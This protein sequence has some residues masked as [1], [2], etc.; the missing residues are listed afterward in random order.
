MRA[1]FR[2]YLLRALFLCITALSTNASADYADE[3]LAAV[4]NQY[5]EEE[6]EGYV[7]NFTGVS[8]VEYIRFV[9]K[10]L[11]INFIFDETEL[12]FNVTIV[13]EE[14]VSGK[15]V[16]SALIQVLRIHNLRLIE[17]NGSLLITSNAGVNA[18]APVIAEAIP[19][20]QEKKGPL[21]TRIFLIKNTSAEAIAEV[22]RPL[23]STAALIEVMAGS[24]LLIVSDILTNVDQIAELLVSLDS[25]Q[26]HLE[27]DTFECKNH[28]PQVLVS[29]AAQILSPFQQGK[30]LL[31]VPQLET[32]SIFIVSTTALIERAISVL[33]D[34]DSEAKG[35]VGLERPE[36]KLFLYKIRF[37]SP[38]FLLQS[39][40]NIADQMKDAPMASPDLLQALRSAKSIKDTHSL[41]FMGDEDSLNKIEEMLSSLDVEKPLVKVLPKERL[42]LYKIQHKSPQFL[43]QSLK[44]ILSEMQEADK[45]SPEL[46]KSLE[47]VQWIKDSH[48]LMFMGDD[49]SIATIQEILSTVD[50]PA[51]A[52]GAPG[53]FLFPLKTASKDQVQAWLNQIADNLSEAPSPDEALIDTIRSAKWIEASNSLFF[54][55]NEYSINRLKEILSSFDF[56]KELPPKAPNFWVYRPAVRKGEEIEAHV[57]EVTDNLKAAGLTNP[58][59]LH[60]LESMQWSSSANTLTFTGDADSL[61]EIKTIVQEYDTAKPAVA[62]AP[63]FWVYHPV[64]RKGEEIEAHVK[65]VTA[66]LKD[67]GLTNPALLNALQSLRW[68]PSTN[69]LTFTGDADSLDE[70]KIIVQEYDTAK[71]AVPG[72]SHFWVYHPAVRKGEEIEAHVKEVTAN[73]KAAGLTNPPLLKALASMQWSPSANTL[74]FTGDTDS[75]NEIKV[76]VEQ[77]D[78]VKPTAPGAP[79]FLVY[80]PVHRKGEEIEAH[81][82]EVTANLKA[83]GLTNPPFLSALESMRWS[84]STN[85]LTFTGDESSLDEIKTIVEGYD[86]KGEAVDL[87]AQLAAK[88]TSFFIYKPI[89]KSP[90]EIQHSLAEIASDLEASGLADPLLLSTL[91]TVR[92]VE[93]TQSF[94]FTGSLDSLEKVSGLLTRIDL[95]TEE[96]VSI[97][98]IGEETFLIYKIQ[99]VTANQLLAS[100]KALTSDL[101]QNEQINRSLIKTLNSAKWVQETNSLLFIGPE[102]SLEEVERLA[103]Q[104]D[105]PSLAKPGEALIEP[106]ETPSSYL[107][108]T[109]KYQSGPEL[110][111]MV[112]EFKDHLA[113]IGIVDKA[114][115]DTV[116]HLKWVEKSHAILI[117]GAP[118]SITKVEELLERFDEPVKGEGLPTTIQALETTSFLVYKLQY[119]QGSAI[120]EALQKIAKEFSAKDG[121]INKTMLDAIQSLQ[122]IQITNSLVSTGTSLALEKLKELIRN[123]D[124]PLKQV[125]IEVLLIET[126]LENTQDFGLQWGSKTQY[127]N[128]FSMATGNFPGGSVSPSPFNLND[129]GKPLAQGGPLRTPIASDVPFASQGFDLGIIGDIILHRGLSFISLGSLV[130]ALQTDSDSVIILNPKIITQDNNNSTVF[131]GQNIPFVGSQV[132]NTSNNTLLTTNVEYRDIGLSLSITPTLSTSDI[133]TLDIVTDISEQLGPATPLGSSGVAG[134]TTSHT[135][136][137]TRV[138]VPNRH[139]LILSGMLRDAKDHAR[140]QIPCLGGLPLLG[141]A[142]SQNSRDNRKSNIIIFL[143]PYIIN[144]FDEY[145]QLTEN[146]ELLLKEE[147]GPEIVGEEIDA[148]LEWV[149]TPEDN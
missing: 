102:K 83:S 37:Q 46:A 123:L 72:A 145:L 119:N 19:G 29:L 104:F 35:K 53:F 89:S 38:E 121:A 22:V 134:I 131:V 75:L 139:F 126:T 117:S 73:L 2:F 100:L 68:T 50:T 97:Q 128:K 130:N 116:S 120:Q 127:L 90:E 144:S 4:N 78:T 34:L 129:I 108:Y 60:A 51:A 28:T 69:T 70:I 27:I 12:Q 149:K 109:P 135:S 84:P 137:N 71:E 142:F 65:E 133:V 96:R 80:H 85:T 56:T 17:Q 107:L 79:H 8:I 74:T 115:F 7:I 105:L 44:Q 101:A 82:Q 91:S 66:S 140:T 111:L 141:A 13:S 32:N 11:G 21:V 54:T 114:L 57:K 39:L 30:T 94:L 9:S 87:S 1:S 20:S 103:K 63:N 55:G 62:Q 33:E 41:M 42:F 122:W 92:Y 118:S 16:L 18:I 86:L 47:S 95:P 98:K 58:P 148:G 43:L 113:Q 64:N 67:S 147:S 88:K 59:L 48:S 23:L 77:Y 40:Q 5:N 124:V 132:N 146:Q 99:F 61:N 45:V 76:I 3:I 26:S 14:P 25:P 36:G 24:N 110:I 31:L 81:M 136:L 125:F 93:S 15:N 106:R 49:E 6:D 143:K 138:T 10:I 52:L 112:V